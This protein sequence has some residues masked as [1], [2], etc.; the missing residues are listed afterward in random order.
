M[1]DSEGREED[2]PQKADGTYWATRPDGTKTLRMITYEQRDHLKIMARTW[3]R[4]TQDLAFDK[5]ANNLAS[6]LE[7]VLSNTKFED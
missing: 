3:L 2:A 5:R 7:G 1:M 6:F 4:N